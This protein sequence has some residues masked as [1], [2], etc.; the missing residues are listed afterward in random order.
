MRH[1]SRLSV[2]GRIARKGDLELGERNLIP[3]LRVMTRLALDRGAY[4]ALR[5]P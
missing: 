2:P 1:L 3:A 4:C 5:R